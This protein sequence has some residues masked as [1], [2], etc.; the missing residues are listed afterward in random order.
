MDTESRDPRIIKTRESVLAAARDLLAGEGPSAVT[1]TRLARET[2]VSR[3]TIYRN[4]SD[5]AAI[6][7]DAIADEDARPPFEPTGDP[8][9]DLT[10]YLELLRSG[11]EMPHTTLLATRIE[12][13][14]HD[15]DTAQAIRT[16]NTTRR[17]L[18]AR[19]L[20][21]TPEQFTDDHSLVVGPLFFQR[22][23]AREP[24]SDELIELVVDAY[25][26]TRRE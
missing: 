16:S 4:W 26:A 9:R 8:R 23:L 3:S 2:G 7:L 15:S 10:T 12:R 17:K 20:D 24:I 25:F 5:P 1:P 21:Q 11:L 18:M 13:A 14:E 19:L 22:F 6:V